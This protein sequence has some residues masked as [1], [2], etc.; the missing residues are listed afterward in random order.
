MNIDLNG[1][2]NSDALKIN[3]MQKEILSDNNIN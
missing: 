2:S 1:F 3:E